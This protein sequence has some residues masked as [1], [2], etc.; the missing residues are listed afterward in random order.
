[1]VRS[2]RR[3]ASDDRVHYPHPLSNHSAHSPLPSRRS[4]RVAPHVPETLARLRDTAAT[5]GIV[6]AS[7]GLLMGAVA[8]SS[9]TGTV[10]DADTGGVP[11]ASSTTPAVTARAD[12]TVT[13]G[14]ESAGPTDEGIAESID[15]SIAESTTP[16]IASAQALPAVRTPAVTDSKATDREPLSAPV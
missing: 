10:S 14:L 11:P 2:G 9:T 13:F 6:L 7:A 5:A 15:P 8:P 16:S 1:M 3:H 4:F 12:A